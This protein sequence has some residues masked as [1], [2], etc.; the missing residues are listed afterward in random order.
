MSGTGM[1][2]RFGFR[3]DFSGVWHL[4]VQDIEVWDQTA[5]ETVKG[6]QR[7]GVGST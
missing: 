1:G 7:V 2:I 3:L 4:A 5:E 6:V